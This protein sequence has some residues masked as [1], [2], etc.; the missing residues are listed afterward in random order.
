MPDTIAHTDAVG[1]ADPNPRVGVRRRRAARRRARR[2][3]LAALVLAAI[4]AL[5]WLVFG[6]A[7]L[8]ATRVDVRGTALLG[9]DQVAHVAQVPLGTPLARI[10]AGAVTRRVASLPEVARVSVTRAWPHT[11]RITV[12]ERQVAFQREVS[13]NGGTAYEWIGADGTVFHTDATRQG[14]PL[15]HSPTN[16]PVLM[17][18]VATVV[19]HLPA[20]LLARVHEMTAATRDQIVL[21]LDDGRQIV[22]GSA[23]DSELKASVIVVLL[24]QPGTVYDVSAPG[25][26]AIR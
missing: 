3:A 6:S 13:V 19:G 17:A 24:L 4:A 14:V 10:D 2:V 16:D 12:T 18:D 23:A 9:T 26:P 8:T 5:V 25:H 1:I 20:E 15:L 21:T 11:V 7:V 22:W